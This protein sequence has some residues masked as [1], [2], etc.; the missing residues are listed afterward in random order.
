MNPSTWKRVDLGAIVAGVQSGEIVGPVPTLLS[1]SDGAALLYG[2][3]IHSLAGEPE[4]G[5][6]WIALAAV[7]ACVRD[8]GEALY[9]DFEAAPESIVERLIA[10][11]VE[12][13]AIVDHLVY[14]RPSESLTAD[15]LARLLDDRSYDVAVIDGVSEA[16]ML[17]GLDPYST[18]DS[19]KF[20]AALPRPIADRGAA[21]LELDHVTKSS[22]QR[23]R[24]AIGSGHKL[25][26][27][28]AAFST[29]TVRAPS[30]THDGLVK[31]RVEKD[32]HGR[33]RSHAS[34][35]VVALV[36]IVP[37]DEGERVSVVLEPPDAIA[38]DGEAF[39]PTE[40]MR[41]VSS[42]VETAPGATGNEVRR[43]VPGKTDAKDLA[44]RL[45]VEEGYVERRKVGRANRHYLEKPFEEEPRPNHDSTA[46]GRG[47]RATATHDSPLKGESR[48]GHARNGHSRDRDL[49]GVVR[50]IG[51]LEDPD[52]QEQTW[53]LLKAGV[54]GG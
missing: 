15:A 27:V 9:L 28:A 11:G 17:L 38:S 23:G 51:A 42:F 36:R 24:W 47:E 53:G 20:Q 34:G 41:K 30:R 29:E 39:R 19:A 54:S 48:S 25:A 18:T 5:K 16:F 40:L 49:Q 3:E 45:L 26:A 12:A 8:G 50:A 37:S 22:E 44:L 4:S 7:A 33:V 10:L 35:G 1:R 13:D 52:L 43:S 31:L 46:T 14:V 6:S 21:T 32:R 2:G